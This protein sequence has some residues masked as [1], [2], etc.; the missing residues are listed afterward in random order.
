MLTTSFIEKA[1]KIPGWLSGREGRLLYE[2]AK[3]YDERGDVVEVGSF[4]GKSTAFLAQAVK[5]NGKGRVVSIDPHLGETHAVKGGPRFGET[6]GKFK[7]NLRDLGLSKLVTPIRKTSREASKSWKGAIAVLNV[8]ALHEYEFAK[9][10]LSLWL[11][12]LVPGGVVICHDA[13][14]PYPE[15]FRA[16]KEK[17]FDSGKFRYIGVSESQIFAV[18]GAPQN[19]LEKLNRW[20]MIFFVQLASDIWHSKMIPEALANFLVKRVLKLFYLNELMVR[21]WLK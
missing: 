8:D 11:P 15:V 9:E 6:F 16:V 18:K 19:S 13:F 17:V 7:K 20:R 14:S 21:L 5:E 4:Q 10:D 3:R 12:Y 2:L 1:S